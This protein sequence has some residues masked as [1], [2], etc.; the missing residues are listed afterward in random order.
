[1]KSKQIGLTRS[2]AEAV[3]YGLS[4]LLTS[5][6]AFLEESLENKAEEKVIAGAERAITRVGDL[7]DKI[8]EYCRTF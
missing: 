4:L 3:R 7:Y 1:M 2:E 6:T 5:K 8:N